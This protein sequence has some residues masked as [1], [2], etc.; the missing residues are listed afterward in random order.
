MLEKITDNVTNLEKNK[1]NKLIIKAFNDNKK[2]IEGSDWA[3][4]W[5]KSAQF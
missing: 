1:Q 2:Y 5:L 4:I 3:N